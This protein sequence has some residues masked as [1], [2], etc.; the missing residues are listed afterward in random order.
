MRIGKWYGFGLCLALGCAVAL[1]GCP[2]PGVSQDTFELWII[3]SLNVPSFA[4]NNR[5]QTVQMRSEITDQLEQVNPDFVEAKT[6]QR[7]EL[8][9][10]EFGDSPSISLNAPVAGVIDSLTING[11]LQAGDVLVAHVFGDADGLNGESELLELD[12]TTKTLMKFGVLP[13]AP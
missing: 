13:T 8:D 7:V 4:N 5:I 12:D 3:N 10:D 9:V 2:A 1:T 6:V 11:P